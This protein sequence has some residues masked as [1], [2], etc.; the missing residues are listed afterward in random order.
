M[1]ET[2][3]WILTLRLED[4][5]NIYFFGVCVCEIEEERNCPAIS[6]AQIVRHYVF[7]PPN[8]LLLVHSSD[9]KGFANRILVNCRAE[10][11]VMMCMSHAPPRTLTPHVYFSLKRKR[12]NSKLR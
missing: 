5:T 11:H 12:L 6:F 2:S 4:I 3:V 9:A 1:L 10:P 7:S 8:L